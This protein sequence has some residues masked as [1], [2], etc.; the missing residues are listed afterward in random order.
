MAKILLA[1]D[2]A[3][4]LVEISSVAEASGHSLVC[5]TSGLDAQEEALANLPDLIILE[6]GLAIF[7]GFEVCRTLREHPDIP[8]GLPILIL[9]SEDISAKQLE[10]AHENAPGCAFH[11]MDATDLKFPDGSFENMICVEAAF[12]FDTRGQFFREAVRVLQPGGRLGR[13]SCSPVG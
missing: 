7:S 12:H 9:S 1:G 6:A 4:S 13:R 8:K 3:A 2:D 10:A 11:L 5:V